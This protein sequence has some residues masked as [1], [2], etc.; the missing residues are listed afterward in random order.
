MGYKAERH[1]ILGSVLNPMA[2]VQYPVFLFFD[3]DLEIVV[4][5]DSLIRAVEPWDVSEALEIF[6]VSGAIIRIHAEGVRRTR[7]TVGGGEV[8]FDGVEQR[9]DAA[10]RFRE[11]LLD[12]I[13]AVKPRRFELEAADLEHLQLRQLAERVAS[14]FE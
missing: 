12:Y 8:V 3:G 11:L 1:V 2:A 4:D 7:F 13:A 5:I 10:V 9:S 14:F 6:D